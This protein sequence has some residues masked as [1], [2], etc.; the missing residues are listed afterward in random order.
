MNG[1][2]LVNIFSLMLRAAFRVIGLSRFRFA[3]AGY[4][5]FDNAWE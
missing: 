3:K 5:V 4:V 2:G 1:S